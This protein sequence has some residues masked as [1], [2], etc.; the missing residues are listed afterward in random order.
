MNGRGINQIIG[1]LKPNGFMIKSELNKKLLV[2]SI[3][4]VIRGNKF[5]GKAVTSTQKLLAYNTKLVDNNMDNIDL[6]II[7]HISNGENTNSLT[8]F[9]PLSL[10]SIERRKSKIKDILCLNS[11]SSDSELIKVAKAARLIL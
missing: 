4:S 9:I 6:K 5:F 11:K 7:Y 1:S 3:I 2:E 8:E 10:S